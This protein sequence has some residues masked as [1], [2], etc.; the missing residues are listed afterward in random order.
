MAG[1]VEPSADE[2]AEMTVLGDV[3]AWAGLAGNGNHA[4]TMVGS[5]LA[6]I[7][8]PAGASIAEFANADSDDYREEFRNWRYGDVLQNLLQHL[9]QNLIQNLPQFVTPKSA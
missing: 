6:L 5:L 8:I 4:G 3:L 7:G 2:L 9:L 1:L